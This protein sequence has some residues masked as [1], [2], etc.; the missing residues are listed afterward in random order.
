MN[1]VRTVNPS[2]VAKKILLLLV[3][4]SGAL[5]PEGKAN[6]Y[7]KVPPEMVPVIQGMEAGMSAEPVK[8]PW[9][10]FVPE[11]AE[12]GGANK[13]PLIFFLHGAGRR[14]SDN[15]GPME[16]ASTFWGEKQKEFPC[17]VLA[18]QCPRGSTWTPLP[19]VEGSRNQ[20]GNYTAEEK[21]MDTMQAALNV[22][23][24]VLAKWP[25]D[26]KRVYV[27]GMS[28]GGYGTWEALMRRPNQWAAAV[29]I[30]GGGDP[31]RV[32]AYKDVPIWV[33][34]GENDAVVP[35]ANSRTMIEA[36]R[37]AGGQ[38]KYTELKK[39]N[40]GSW[41]PAFQTPELSTWLFA[42]QRP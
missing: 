29:P 35:A 15:V 37:E 2:Q 6:D 11:G 41:G 19:F 24:E 10:L 33:W 42:Q 31:S 26:R 1:A 38:P 14:G 16:L 23:E 12:P 5:M 9:R 34:H 22:L 30:C 32:A 7:P 20:R 40:H 8:I 28:M 17:F 13:F 3:A 21:P 36:L 39:V 27:M 4:A 18:P 25:V